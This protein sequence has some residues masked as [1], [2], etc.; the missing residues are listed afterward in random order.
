MGQCKCA[1]E[2]REGGGHKSP[3]QSLIN[4]LSAPSKVHLKLRFAF[5]WNV[6]P[7]GGHFINNFVNMRVGDARPELAIRYT[8]ILPLTCEITNGELNTNR[9]C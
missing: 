9:P 6:S 3:W 1:G 4:V 5:R 2:I 7:H 8:E